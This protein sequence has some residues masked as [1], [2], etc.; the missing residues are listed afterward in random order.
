MAAVFEAEVMAHTAAGN[1]QVEVM[2]PGHVG[3]SVGS[4]WESPDSCRVQ[5]TTTTVTVV[6]GENRVKSWSRVQRG[7]LDALIIIS[8]GSR[9][10]V[11]QAS[12]WAGTHPGY[13]D[14]SHV[15]PA[16]A[17]KGFALDRLACAWLHPSRKT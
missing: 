2:D 16:P 14:A 10:S 3:D 12:T 4:V 6:G 9:S 8:D 11:R 13:L 17:D 5:S 15:H 1:L 7:E